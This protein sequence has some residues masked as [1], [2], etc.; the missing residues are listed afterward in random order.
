M[1]KGEKNLITD[2][3]GVRV[4]HYTYRDDSNTTGVTG[5]I[6]SEGNLFKSK[7]VASAHVI[8]GFGKS[9]GILQVQ[10]LGTLETPILLT[11]TFGIGTG[12]NSIVN[13][14]LKDNPDIGDTTG[15]VNPV[16][17]E[18]NDGKINNIRS[19][20]LCEDHMLKA[21]ENAGDE[22]NQGDVGAGAGMVCYGLKGGIGSASRLL[23]I[24]AIEY[25][26][27]ILVLSNFGSMKDLLYFGNPVG[28]DILKRTGTDNEP[29]KGSIIIV[30]A[31][32]L[33]LDSSQLTRTLK[34]TQSGIARTGAYS[35][36]GS[37]EIA[38]GFST[39]NRIDHYPAGH[40][41]NRSVLH[42]DF[43]DMVFLGTV[44]ATEEAILNSLINANPSVKRNGRKVH[45][46]A[47]F[48][49]ILK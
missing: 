47:E 31:T 20:V 9:L 5:I 15:T 39:A 12:F 16:V 22:F 21:L 4:G 44:Q 14:M 24:E 17:C 45:S 48:K 42:E 46:L 28:K 40:I 30:L 1:K 3:P 41:I 18:C 6:P 32:D 33:P 7:L 38:I 36:N 29:D 37:G 35:G 34:R 49:D 23:K 13:Y 43:M 10:E 19:T 11:N 26:L 8:N 27:G 2:V 25:N